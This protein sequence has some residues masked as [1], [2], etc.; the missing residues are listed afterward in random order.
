[1]CFVASPG[2][3]KNL[4]NRTGAGAVARGSIK[5]FLERLLLRAVW[6][7]GSPFYY[8]S[9]PMLSPQLINPDVVKMQDIWG[10]PGA[11]TS[12][13]ASARKYNG[14]EAITQHCAMR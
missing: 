3:S 11:G 9:A 7:V 13:Q 6:R 12:G 2:Q 4:W 1:M 8:V 5:T 10:G 14:R